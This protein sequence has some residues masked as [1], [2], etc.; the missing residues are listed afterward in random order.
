MELKTVEIKVPE[1]MIPFILMSNTKDELRRN[2]LLMYPYIQDGTI[3]HGK[4][5]EI[6]G[7]HK[8]DLIA[9]YGELG[10]EYFQESALELE[11]DLSAIR[12]ARRMD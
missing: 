11:T 9:L 6:L 4:A 3:S 7:M 10:L 2:A 5:A 12:E 8:L 1:E